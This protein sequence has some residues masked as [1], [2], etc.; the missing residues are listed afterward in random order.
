MTRFR[1]L[2]ERVRYRLFFVPLVAVIVTI[3][4]SQATLALDNSYSDSVPDFLRTEFGSGRSVLSALAGGL[5][6]SVTLL[7]S[8]ML[9]AVQVAASQFS[10]RTIRDW[11]GSP[12]Q[13]RAV[14]FVLSAAVY[15]LLIIRS[16]NEQGGT[17]IEAPHISILIAI[18][19]G[20]M[21]LLT[22]V[23]SVDYLADSMRIGRV[24]N[25][26]MDDTLKIVRKESRLFAAEAPRATPS[27]PEV[28]VTPPDGAVAIEAAEAGWIQYIDEDALIEATAPGQTVYVVAALGSFTFQGAPVAWVWPASEPSD[29]IRDS[30][31]IGDSRTL[32]QDVSFGI[33]QLV[34]IAL[35][36]ISP[37]VNDPNTA[38][39]IVVHLGQ[40]LVA[41]WEGPIQ[42]VETLSKDRR[43]IR[44]ELTHRDYLLA[45]LAP[46]RRYGA[47][48]FNVMATVIRTVR[49]VRQEVERRD[50]A[51]PIEPLN[52][53]LEELLS[54][55]SQGTLSERDKE[56]LTILFHHGETTLRSHASEETEKGPSS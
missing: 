43:V 55:V 5:I 2:V 39:D 11:I 21:C 25:T 51:G 24:A 54:D 12:T 26:I 6:T 27:T 56:R 36:A 1:Q 30:L 33:L 45:A 50:L 23:H 49:L 13:K 20:V 35:R 9:V 8:L 10:P 18:S 17:G 40:I 37:G 47:D 41:I 3:G 7:L 22:V 52:E 15:C 31:A 48:D 34:D 53:F 46:L 29:A 4:L 42:P 14:G 38:S 16:M 19:L 44:H 28:V 32:Q